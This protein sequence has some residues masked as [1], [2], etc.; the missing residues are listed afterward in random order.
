MKLAQQSKA[1]LDTLA[2]FKQELEKANSTAAEF[3]NLVLSS[4]QQNNSR[5]ATLENS[6]TQVIQ[7]NQRI[8]QLLSQGNASSNLSSTLSNNSNTL[9]PQGWNP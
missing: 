5:L 3:Q 7:E 9:D 8:E 4:Q 2:L 1:T 6:M